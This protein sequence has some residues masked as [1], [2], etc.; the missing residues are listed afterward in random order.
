MGRPALSLG[1]HGSF[2][3][4][5][6][7]N[8]FRSRC[9]VRDYDG[10]IREVQ[11]VGRSKAAAEKALSE[12]LRDR[13]RI[14][15]AADITPDTRIA[16]VAEVWF[17]DFSRQD[18]SPTTV[19]AYRD[20]LDKHVVPALGNVRVRELTVGLVDRHLRAVEARHG[21]ALAKQT[22]T[23]LGQ[24]VALAVRH[25]ALAQNPV[26][27]TSP[28]STKPKSPP[29]ALTAQ[30]AAQLMA[31]LTYD[32]QA[33]RRDLPV[34]VATMLATGLRLGEA[35]GLLWRSVDLEVASLEVEAT[36]VRIKGQG[37]LRKST[38]TTA[39]HRTLRLPRWAVDMLRERAVINAAAPD[40]P[41]FSSPLGNLRDASNTAADLRDAFEAAGFAWATSHV[42]RKTTAS[43]LDAAG[44]TAREIA[45]QLGHARPSITMDRY[46]G[47]KIASDRG[48]VVL[49]VLR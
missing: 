4:Y 31:L 9:K 33:V 13:S 24:V 14:D 6:E 5:P 49:E 34:L 11:R 40:T 45:D 26:R 10:V 25:D 12:A 27:D 35:C 30:Q 16:A 29:R 32:D 22:K 17:T 20:R 43:V 41:V 37:L 46:M 44:L 23:V 8:Q 3:T 36:V 39:G 28:I 42:L 7:G 21:A 15:A 48:A 47:R 19:A 38:K 18:R 1:C 2:R